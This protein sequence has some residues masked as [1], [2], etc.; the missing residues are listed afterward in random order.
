MRLLRGQ[1]EAAVLPGMMRLLALTAH[2]VALFVLFHVSCLMGPEGLAQSAARPSVHIAAHSWQP[3]F[4]NTAAQVTL[5][6]GI[7][8]SPQW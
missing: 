7:A 6:H 1:V 5:V 4:A 2:G 3:G 8:I